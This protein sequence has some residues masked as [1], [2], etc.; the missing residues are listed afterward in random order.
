M[1]HQEPMGW[2][3]DCRLAP[4]GAGGLPILAAWLPLLHSLV[5]LEVEEQHGTSFLEG[6]DWQWRG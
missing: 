6:L 4:R 5:V 2:L 3:R 1:R